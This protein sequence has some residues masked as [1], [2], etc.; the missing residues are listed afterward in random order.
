[1]LWQEDYSIGIQEIDDQHKEMVVHFDSI[2]KCI[3]SGKE[4]YLLIQHVTELVQYSKF[5]FKF[6]EALM[7]LSGYPRSSLH[8]AQHEEFF[9]V[10][11]EIGP[12]FT[13]TVNKSSVL[14]VASVSMIRHI[15]DDD[16]LYAEYLLSGVPIVKTTKIA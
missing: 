12:N 15:I 14:K 6:E 13:S 16:R 7:R 4:F 11:A 2:E 10:L 9:T 1:V 5:H 8:K 3:E